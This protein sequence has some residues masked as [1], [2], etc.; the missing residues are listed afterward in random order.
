MNWIQELEDFYEKQ[1]SDFARAV[2]ESKI[3]QA[4]L[5]QEQIQNAIAN[6]FCKYPLQYRFFPSAEIIIQLGKDN[7]PLE[8][9]SA[10]GAVNSLPSSELR[11][12]EEERLSNIK[13]INEII[14][15]ISNSK[16]M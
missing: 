4:G 5:S 14:R 12:T 13:R 11:M 15:S 7:I 16:K 1:L 6:C 9:S 10:Y 2:Y 8:N 3:Q